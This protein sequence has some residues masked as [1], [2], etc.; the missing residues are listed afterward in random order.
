MLQIY[1]KIAPRIVLM[2]KSIKVDKS[3]KIYITIVYEDGD[4]D[5]VNQLKLY[6]NKN[7]PNGLKNRLFN[8]KTVTYSNF[9]NAPKN[10]FIFLFDTHTSNIEK[11]V[12]YSMDNKIITMSYSS[13]YLNN[14][15]LLSLHVGK[16]LKPYINIKAAKDSGIIFKNNLIAVSKIFYEEK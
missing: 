16:S 14:R 11:V 5:S 10:S 12:K 15:V 3:K 6:I 9:K 1:A 4:E 2:T 7:Y 13:K 8:I